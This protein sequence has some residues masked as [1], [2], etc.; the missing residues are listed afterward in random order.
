M[1]IIN[2]VVSVAKEVLK[3]PSTTEYPEEKDGLADNYRGSLKLDIKTC[4]S[5][6]ACAIIC[7]RKRR[8]SMLSKTALI[9]QLQNE[10]YT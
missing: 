2:S 4:I 3:S 8:V 5:C 7:P 1:T 10:V 6:S 9:L